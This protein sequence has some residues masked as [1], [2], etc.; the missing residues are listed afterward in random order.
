MYKRQYQFTLEFSRF[1]SFGEFVEEIRVSFYGH[2]GDVKKLPIYVYAACE[3]HPPITSR[4]YP[5]LFASDKKSCS[6]A[7]AKSVPF[8]CKT[9]LAVLNPP[10]LSAITSDTAC[11]IVPI[12]S[13]IHICGCW[14]RRKARLRKAHTIRGYIQFS[15]QARQ[16]T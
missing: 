5:C 1:N 14:T 10:P 11:L 6:V 15:S 9:I 7:C 3:N 13:L 8:T 12:L 4:L 2:D 16:R